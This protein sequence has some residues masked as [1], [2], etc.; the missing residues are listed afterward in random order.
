V[1]QLERTYGP[2]QED[3]FNQNKL[4]WHAHYGYRGATG[5]KTG[6]TSA[7]G[8]CLVA[9][10]ERQGRSMVAVVLKCNGD[11][12]IEA[13]RLLDY[14]FEGFTRVELVRPDEIITDAG[15]KYGAAR[16][17]LET[18]DYLYYN[19]PVGQELRAERRVELKGN[20][21]APL[22]TGGLTG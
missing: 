18:A 17:V 20:I 15:V 19:F 5:I 9:S 22:E 16:A 10:A 7:A 21:E 4:L 3:F 11:M 12:W 14:G 13:A 6:Y 8:M 2:V 1:E